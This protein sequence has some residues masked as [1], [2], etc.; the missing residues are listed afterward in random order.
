MAPCQGIDIPPGDREWYLLTVVELDVH[1]LGVVMTGAGDFDPNG[2]KTWTIAIASTQRSKT[3]TE[4]CI[5]ACK[6]AR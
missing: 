1:V 6:H 3:I 5:E 4:Q 2:F